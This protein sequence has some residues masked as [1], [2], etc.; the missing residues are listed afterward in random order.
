VFQIR[1]GPREKPQLSQSI[2]DNPAG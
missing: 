1:S 2:H